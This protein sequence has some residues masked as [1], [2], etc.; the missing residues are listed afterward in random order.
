[1]EARAQRFVGL[2]RRVYNAYLC[3]SVHITSC[4]TKFY[5]LHFYLF[6]YVKRRFEEGIFVSS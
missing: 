6:F 1:M 5:Q 2:N 3:T 4:R